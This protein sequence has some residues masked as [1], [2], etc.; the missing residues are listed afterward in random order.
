VEVVAQAIVVRWEQ[1]V[2]R[3]LASTIINMATAQVTEG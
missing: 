2:V 3:H 1:T